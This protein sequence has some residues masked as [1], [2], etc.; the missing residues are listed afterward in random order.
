MTEVDLLSHALCRQVLGWAEEAAR[1]LGIRDVELHMGAESSALTR[2]ANNTI[3]Q[4]VA[5]RGVALSVRTAIDGRTARAS[6][7]R[8]AREDVRRAVEQAA[9][10]TRAAELDPHLPD[11]LG[12]QEVQDA[13]RWFA[14]TASC[15]PAE[16][17]HAVKSAID[18]AER[19]GQIAAG[20]FSTGESVTAVLNSRG[21]FC[22]HAETDA[23]FS[24]TAMAADSSGWAK[25]SACDLG[26]LDLAS[27]AASATSKA[28]LSSAPVVIDP[29]RYRVVLEH[30]AVLDLVGQIF[31]DFSATAIE[32]QRS[33]LTE[34]LGR[35]LFGENIS[36]VDDCHHPMQHGAPFDGE[37]MPRK[38]L[39]LID[40]GAVREVACGRSA[41]L[42]TGAPPTGHGLPL[43]N[44]AGE[45]AGNIVM[46]GG[47]ESVE[48]LVAG[49]DR[50]ILVTRLWYIRE[51]DP[52]AKHMTGM[53]RDGTFL[54]EDG[55]VV[56]GLR[57]FRFNQSVVDLLNSVEAMSASR[58]T[59]GEEAFDMVVPAMRAANF[60][61][62][63]VT[64]F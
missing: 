45:M 15:T 23:V 24:M 9:A 61:F 48:S 63:E 64:R 7:N 60:H 54:V 8:L 12:P 25:R 5:S 31:S 10:L 22:Y 2:F 35:Q 43:P 6:T 62:S 55:R 41:G 27:L 21:L 26:E 19:E 11:M 4:N 37:G 13:P 46:S 14:S 29:G 52:A 28:K 56:R 40:R 50:G 36:I 20:I 53:T 39:A 18:E 32:E 44:E 17:A 57:N 33:F 49:M 58:R 34:K 42:R 59:S 47:E 16:R 51:V 38:S 30:A 3:H 1:S